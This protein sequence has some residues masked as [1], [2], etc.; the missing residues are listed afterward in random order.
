M[1]KPRST[2]PKTQPRKSTDERAETYKKRLEE[3]NQLTQQLDASGVSPAVKT[4]K[5]KQRDDKIAAI[6]T[7]EKEINEFRTT[8]ERQ[9]QEQALRMRTGIVTDI[10][11]EITKLNASSQAF[12]YDRSGNSLNGVPVLVYSRDSADASS[13]VIAGLNG[14]SRSPFRGLGDVTVAVVDMNR[15]FKNYNR[16]KDSE[17]K[18]N[19]AKEAAKKEFD[20]RSETYTKALS[21]INR[22][23]QQLDSPTLSADRKISMT[24]ERDEKIAT[25]KNMEREINEFRQTRERQLQEQASRMREGIIKMIIDAIL[26]GVKQTNGELI[27][28]ISGLS[29]NGVPVLPYL[30]GVPDFSDDV[31]TALNANGTVKFHQSPVP[32]RKLRFGVVDMNRAFKGWPDTAPSEKRI[33]DAKD[34]AKKEYDARADRY[35]KALDE[36][37]A[38]NQKLDSPSLSAATKTA[39]ASERDEK[40]AKIKELEREINEFRTNREKELQDQ[41][42]KMREEIVAKIT[43]ALKTQAA[44][45][46]FNL[47]FDSSGQSMNGVPVVILAPGMPDLTDKVLKK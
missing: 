44:T 17:K 40:I 11:N 1:R 20:D 34:A 43:A 30:S 28:D 45:E 35:K 29:M 9:L 13:D 18:I 31:I 36:I 27:F 26:D 37:N 7:M 8:R 16:T 3:I 42:V 32:T 19:E 47:I 6:K 46:N 15:I 4:E 5:A 23:N 12:I 2:R 14:K 10:T 41:A 39:L 24:K 21:E 33:N 22:L 25:L 38:L